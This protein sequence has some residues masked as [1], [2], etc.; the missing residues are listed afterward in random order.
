MNLCVV[1]M[2]PHERSRMHV[3]GAERF[4]KTHTDSNI[5]THTHTHTHTHM[6]THARARAQPMT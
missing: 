2:M 4:P 6:H 1:A 3:H 5:V